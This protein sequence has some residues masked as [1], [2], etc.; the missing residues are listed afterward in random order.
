M[1]RDDEELIVVGVGVAILLAMTKQPQPKID[2]WGQITGW[3]WPVPDLEVNGERYP[4]VI[5]SGFR[6]VDRPTH[7]GVDIM[8]ARKSATDMIAE[9][10]PRVTDAGG[11]R[12]HPRFFAPQDTPVL[13]AR[14][15]R[16]WATLRLPTGLAI[17]LDHGKPWA[18][19]YFHLASFG[20]PEH[21]NGRRNDGGAPFEVAAGDQIGVMGHAPN[22]GELLR[23][24]HFETWFKGGSGRTAGVDPSEVMRA[25]ERSS[26]TL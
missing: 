10:P 8:Y 21:T 16:V 7:D 18:T 25:W 9:F 4:A 14:A 24:L 3:H 23:H 11:A 17:V 13:A 5:T 15:G 1:R 26:W 20:V 19:A 2:D 6:S 12:A 22:D